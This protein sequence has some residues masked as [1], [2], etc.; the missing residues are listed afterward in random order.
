MARRNRKDSL[1]PF[2]ALIWDVLNSKAYIDLPAS[3]GKALPYFLGKVKCSFNDPQRYLIEFSFSYSEGKR[4]GF[5]TATFSNVIKALVKKGFI[6]PVDKGGL[7]S[8]GKS[9]N[10]FRLSRRWEKYGNADFKDIEWECFLPRL[11]T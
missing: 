10:I 11:R 8:N 7:R 2:V 1:P 4:L 9:Y 3:A 6:D 5:A